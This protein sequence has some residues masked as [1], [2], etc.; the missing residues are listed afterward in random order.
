VPPRRA[1][2]W[3]AKAPIRPASLDSSPSRADLDR[4]QRARQPAAR[5]RP[6]GALVPRR[7]LL[8]RNT[9]QSALSLG[10]GPRSG[11]PRPCARSS[12]W[13]HERSGGGRQ[14][15]SEERRARRRGP[16]QV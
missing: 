16:A 8:R 10:R 3:P 13:Q 14:G 2:T 5:N 1:P 9:D 11:V 7:C 6:A 15:C 12:H 4:L